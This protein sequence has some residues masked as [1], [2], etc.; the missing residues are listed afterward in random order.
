MAVK[1]EDVLAYLENAIVALLQG[2]AVE[3]KETKAV[4]CFIDS[5]Y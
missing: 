3:V 5:E 1:K 2:E 4:G